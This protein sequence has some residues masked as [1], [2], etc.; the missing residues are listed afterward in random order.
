[1]SRAATIF[2]L[3]SAVIVAILVAVFVPLK[4]GGAKPV[5]SALFDFDPDDV[6]LIKITNGDD[7]FELRRTDDGWFTGPVQI[8]RASVDA[9]Q[10]AESVVNE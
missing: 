7:V 10:F 9:V 2:L 1:M 8:D 6:S 3:V 5:G 4:N